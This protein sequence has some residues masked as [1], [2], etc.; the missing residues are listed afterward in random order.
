MEP[1]IGG[2]RVLFIYNI[3][4]EILDDI[5][6]KETLNTTIK[7]MKDFESK[8]AIL[9]TNSIIENSIELLNPI[10]SVIPMGN[11]HKKE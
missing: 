10:K 6:Y 9:K 1:I 11:F 5:D 8:L 7:A 3:R 4:D 2:A